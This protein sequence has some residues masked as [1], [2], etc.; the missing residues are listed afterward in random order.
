LVVVAVVEEAEEEEVVGLE[1]HE[2]Q[3][4][5]LSPLAAP[6]ETINLYSIVALVALEMVSPSS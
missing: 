3:V 4:P 5:L 6:L 1:Q 2:L